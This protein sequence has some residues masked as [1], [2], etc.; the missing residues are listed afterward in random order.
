MEQ[1]EKLE[2]AR[3]AVFK[4][5][6]FETLKYSDY[7]YGK[8]QFT[9]EVYDLVEECKKIGIDSFQTKYAEKQPS[10]L[11]GRKLEPKYRDPETGKTWAGRGRKPAFVVHGLAIGKK[12]ED[13]KI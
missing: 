11:K 3:I 13:F 2:I 7:M 6:D 1:T 10:K 5:W 9:D 8:E 4:G 12:L